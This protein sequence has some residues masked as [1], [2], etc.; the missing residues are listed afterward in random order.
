MPTNVYINNFES[1]PEQRLVESLII[2]SIKFYGRDFYYIPRKQSGSFDQLY[3]EDPRK[4]FTEAHLIEMYIKNVEAFEGEGD[5]ASRFGLEIRDQTT[6]TVAIRRFE[7]LLAGNPGLSAIELTRPR[8]GD[9]I[10]MD[11]VRPDPKSPG[12]AGMFFEIQFVE[13]EAIFYQTGALQVYDLRCETFTYSNE[14]F[15]TGVEIIDA[16]FANGVSSYVTTGNTMPSSITSDNT[17]IEAEANAILDL[18]EDSPFG[19]FG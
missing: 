18:S 7:A 13:H 11:F 19:E 9:L 8:E 1:S 10:F 3:G 14:D 16:A 12:A 5:L 15:A 17:I 2:E 6:L 4:T